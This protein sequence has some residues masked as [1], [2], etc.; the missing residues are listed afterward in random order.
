MSTNIREAKKRKRRSKTVSLG[1]DVYLLLAVFTLVVFGLVM[2]YSASTD[3]AIRYEHPPDFYFSKQVRALFVALVVATVAVFMDY[4]YWRRLAVPAMLGTILLLILVLII[5]DKDLGSMR[6]FKSG[7][8]MPG[9]LAK[10]FLVIYLSVWLYSKRN[11]LS[12]VQLGLIPLALILGLICGLILVQP[13]LSAAA[14]IVVLGGL[15]F[16]LA[17]GDLRQIA[18]L[19][20]VAFLVGWLVVLAYDQGQERL[21]TYKDSFLDPMQAS[22]HVK[23]SLSAFVSGGLFGDGLGQ[24]GAKFYRLP[25]PP[26]DSIFAVVAQETG[27]V[28]ATIMVILYGILLW[29]G[30]VIARKAP[31]MLGSLLAGGLSLWLALEAFMNMA[32]M[33]NLLPFAGNAL[34]FV[35]AGGSNLVVSLLAVGILLNISRM[36]KEHEEEVE[37][38]THAAVGLRRSDRRG[39]V[40]RSRSAGSSWQSGN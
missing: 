31:D 25:L 10:I 14:T 20:A 21:T 1:F 34:P 40:S 24:G 27:L 9:E 15:L 29:R 2:L 28:G 3:F 39:R 23:Q 36:T 35:S 22:Y 26:T 6:A 33:V 12:D 32:V 37:R 5:G 38:N 13:D 16:F 19:L 30:M 11:F 17:G 7:S 4:H 18:V 8:Y